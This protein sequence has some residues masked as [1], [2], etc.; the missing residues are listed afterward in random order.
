MYLYAL[1]KIYKS[2]LCALNVSTSKLIISKP[3][4]SLGYFSIIEYELKEPKALLTKLLKD[5]CNN[6]YNEREEFTF[7]GKGMM[8]IDVINQNAEVSVL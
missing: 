2:T 3:K 6:K 5:D 4:N 7:N 1:Y 8:T